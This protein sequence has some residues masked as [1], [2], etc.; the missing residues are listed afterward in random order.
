MQIFFNDDSTNLVKFA[1]KGD[2]DNPFFEGAKGAIF[3]KLE[4]DTILLGLGDKDK[5]SKKTF[6]EAIYKLSLIHI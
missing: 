2:S 3:P 6:K 5:F 1:F 4:E